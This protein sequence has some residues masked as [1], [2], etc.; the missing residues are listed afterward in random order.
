M[1]GPSQKISNSAMDPEQLK[2]LL[3]SAEGKRLLQLLQ[4]DGGAALANAAKAME[5]GDA[6]SAQALLSPLLGSEGENLAGRLCNQLE[7]GG[8]RPQTRRRRG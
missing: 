1:M 6:A 4:S 7:A 2:Q 8:I 3:T 5:R